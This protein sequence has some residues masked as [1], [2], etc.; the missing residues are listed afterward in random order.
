MMLLYDFYCT[1]AHASFI[2]YLL[3]LMKY[4]CF[5]YCS[6]SHIM[7]YYTYKIF[8]RSWFC[9][10]TFERT[11]IMCNGASY[12]EAKITI[13]TQQLNETPRWMWQTDGRLTDP[14]AKYFLLLWNQLPKSC[15]YISAEAAAV[16]V[17]GSRPGA[18]RDGSNTN[19]TNIL[20]CSTNELLIGR[21]VAEKLISRLVQ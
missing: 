6:L 12:S 18:G 5:T 16:W 21:H 3:W 13:K 2:V 8:Y 17:E 14:H 10:K 9:Y 20:I 11:F 15:S 4:D 19:A 1:A 7:I